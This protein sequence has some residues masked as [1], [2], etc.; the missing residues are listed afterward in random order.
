MLT[1]QPA[2]KNLDGLSIIGR[3]GWGRT[4]ARA[5]S[6]SVIQNRIIIFLPPCQT[7]VRPGRTVEGNM[8]LKCFWLLTGKQ[9]PV[10]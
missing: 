5:V 2:C 9:S 7:N 1:E 3:T 8:H 6:V 10:L 4:R